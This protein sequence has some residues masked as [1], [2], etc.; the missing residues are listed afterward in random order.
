MKFGGLSVLAVCGAGLLAQSAGVAGDVAQDY[1]VLH[2]EAFQKVIDGKQV[3]LFTIHNARGMQVSITNYGARVEQILVPDRDGR[4]GDVALGYESIEQVLAGQ[5]SMGAFIGRYANRI[6][7]ASFSLDG[8][9][10]HLTDASH[11]GLK[12][13]RFRVFDA[14]QIGPDAVQ[15]SLL[16][17][18][19][20]EGFPGTLPLR[21]VY[22]VTDNNELVIDYQ[23]VAVDKAT[24]VNFTNHTFFNLSGRPGTTILD[25]E[26]MLSADQVLDVD[27]KLMPTGKFRD[28]NGTP[29]DFRWSRPIG[30]D[31]RG[32]YDLLRYANGYDHHYV[33]RRADTSGLSLDAKLHDPSSGRI[34]EVWS[35]EPGIQVFT[36]N[37]LAGK[38]PR[39]IGKGGVPY[40]AQGAVCLE[41][42][43]FPDS[44]NHANFPSTVLRPG[45]WYAGSIVYKFLV[46][47]G[48]SRSR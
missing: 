25:H 9:A 5:G 17:Q 24:V 35:T 46:D 32:D 3:D 2:R 48:S 43:H 4:M 6:G 11:G 41:P 44:P 33:I 19:G 47:S 18:D 21:V 7:G 16:F 42:S 23:A 22:K 28:V 29:L 34:M 36:A 14:E 30:R 39:D 26:L 40:P 13:S 27:A 15:M 10:Y 37:S 45:Q 31:I 38:I 20:E 8:V 12:G 1:V